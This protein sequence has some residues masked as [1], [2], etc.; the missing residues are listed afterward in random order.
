M[1]SGREANRRDEPRMRVSAP[2]LTPAASTL[3]ARRHAPG[4]LSFRSAGGEPARTRR[5]RGRHAGFEPR[6]R[7]GCLQ[8][9][10]RTDETSEDA[11]SAPQLTP[12]AS[13]YGAIR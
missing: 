8:A 3:R 6:S 13:L 5:S 12:A 11:R 10:K 9:E 2:Q 4:P 7:G 1:S